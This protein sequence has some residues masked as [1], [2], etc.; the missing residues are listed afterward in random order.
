[1]FKYFV[2]ISCSLHSQKSLLSAL[3]SCILEEVE[4]ESKTILSVPDLKSLS[5]DFLGMCKNDISRREKKLLRWHFYPI[6]SFQ[7][8]RGRER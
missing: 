5:V 8:R 7:K 2:L 4:E 3:N 6:F 1:M